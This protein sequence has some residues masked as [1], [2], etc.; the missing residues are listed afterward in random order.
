MKGRFIVFEGIDGSGKT[1]QLK[2]LGERLEQRGYRFL[3]T[4]EPGG[5]PIGEAVRKILL[6]P[7]HNE[8]NP[9]AEALL[10]AAARAQHVAQVIKPALLDGQIVLCDRFVDSS[11]AY[12]G[13]ARG[14][15]IELLERINEPATAGLRPDLVL[16]LDF[17][18]AAGL[19]RIAG[20]GRAADRIEQE[21]LAFHHK[22][23]DGYFTL[24][25]R[26]PRRYRVIDANGTIEQ[27]HRDII[28]LV[29]EVLA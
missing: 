4:R 8:L 9:V 3:Y 15:S 16:L 14:L 26:D 12:Q 11:L 1:T 23:R 10:Y 28:G 2:L 29:E 27:I 5:T 19:E 22:V 6:D 21:D 24:A 7:Q 25:G 17:V 13:F 20:A 18:S